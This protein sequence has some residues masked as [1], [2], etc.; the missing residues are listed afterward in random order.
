MT[1]NRYRPMRNP[2]TDSMQSRRHGGRRASA[3]LGALTLSLCVACSADQILD[4]EDI[5]VAVPGSVNDPA[6]LPSILAGAIGDFGNAW[7][8]GGDFNQVTLAG[9]LSDELMNTE[10][11]PTRIENDQRRQQYQSNGSLQN[12]FYAIQQAR[13]SADFAVASY[14]K[15]EQP[16]NVG[17]AEALNVSA[18]SYILLAE[19]YCS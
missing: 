10:T 15:L 14:A 19:N 13:A 11:F 12:L 16:T 5:D 2:M 7:N 8:G 9:Q 18:I 1:A 3:L 4:V 17:V 6:A